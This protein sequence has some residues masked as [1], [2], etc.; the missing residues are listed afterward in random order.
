MTNVV[1]LGAGGFAREVAMIAYQNGYHVKGYLSDSKEEHGLKLTYGTC[2]G[3]IESIDKDYRYFVPGIG[4]PS[5]R[6]LLVT[7][8]L[9]AGLMPVRVTSPGSNIPPTVFTAN[10]HFGNGVVICAGVSLTVDI[11]VMS[12]VNLNLNCTIG[13]DSVIENYCNLS[14]GV[15]ISGKVYLEEG[16]DIGTGVVVLPGVRIGKGSV[17]GAGAVVTNDVPPYS[18][19]VGVPGKVIK[20]L[21]PGDEN[22]FI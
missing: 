18:V 3:T 17:I 16:V 9:L 4:S 10:N 1:I 20:T 8:A 14:P 19:V 22:V 15:H 12:Y 13:H 7:R 6:K 21:V 5:L 11:E 2:L